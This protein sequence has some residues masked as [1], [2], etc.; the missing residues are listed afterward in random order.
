MFSLCDQQRARQREYS[1]SVTNSE[2]A[3]ENILSLG[4]INFR[5]SLDNRFPPMGFL[6]SK[7]GE[8]NIGGNVW[9]IEK[10]PT[11]CSFEIM[12]SR[13]YFMTN[14]DYIL[15]ILTIQWQYTDYILNIYWLC[16]DY[17]LTMYWLYIDYILT[18]HRLHIDYILTVYWLYI[19]YIL[20]AY[21]LH[22][23]YT[24]TIYWLYIDCILTAYWL[25]WLYYLYIDFILT[26][27]TICLDWWCYL[28]NSARWGPGT[29]GPLPPHLPYIR[30]S[31]SV[32]QSVSEHSVNI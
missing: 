20:T 16:I 21:W 4:S 19:D 32:S 13:G 17:I 26:R 9:N 12:W 1:L 18:I 29:H 28:C 7:K 11:T 3:N 10:Y 15:T 22:I 5:G 8:D 24:L 2:P 27:L 23:D 31:Q 25:Y 6:I 14:V 30:S